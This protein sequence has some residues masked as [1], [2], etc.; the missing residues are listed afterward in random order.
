M[1]AIRNIAPCVSGSL[2]SLHKYTGAGVACRPWSHRSSTSGSISSITQ[3]DMARA[4]LLSFPPAAAGARFAP[5]PFHA[6]CMLATVCALHPRH[7]HRGICAALREQPGA[8]HC[9]NMKRCG[10]WCAAQYAHS[11]SCSDPGSAYYGCTIDFWGLSVDV[12]VTFVARVGQRAAPLRNG[13]L[14]AAALLGQA[15]AL[16]VA[17]DHSIS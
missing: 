10:Q 13:H 17:N 6:P 14:P 7:H 9:I 5:L 16:G 12:Y 15:D 4:C 2:A 8:L 1:P 3:Q 11:S